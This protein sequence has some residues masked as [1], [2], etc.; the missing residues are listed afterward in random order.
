M[1]SAKEQPIRNAPNFESKEVSFNLDRAKV[2]KFWVPFTLFLAMVSVI[3]LPR[4][5][6]FYVLD[7]N[8][9][10]R[11]KELSG[12]LLIPGL[13]YCC[14]FIS[15]SLLNWKNALYID[16]NGLVVN[17]ASKLN[18]IRWNEIQ[19]IELGQ[20]PNDKYSIS[21]SDYCLAITY[22]QNGN[23]FKHCIF[24]GVYTADKETVIAT[25]RNHFDIV[26]IEGPVSKH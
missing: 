25:I 23:W 17:D 19:K 7:E 16:E 3:V 8:I 18:S 2:L 21:P 26:Q 6:A 22:R 1:K 20:N 13:L 4:L 15:K 9:T 12:L 10:L 11:H 5:Y 24:T 14:L